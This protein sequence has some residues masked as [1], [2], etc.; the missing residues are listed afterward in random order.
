MATQIQK[1]FIFRLVNISSTTRLMV[2]TSLTETA[3][4]FFIVPQAQVQNRAM[5]LLVAEEEILSKGEWA[6]FHRDQIKSFYWTLCLNQT[7]DTIMF[8]CV[9]GGT[10]SAIRG[11]KHFNELSTFSLRIQT[12]VPMEKATKLLNPKLHRIKQVLGHYQ[13]C[14]IWDLRSMWSSQVFLLKN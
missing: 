9:C 1:H 4:P 14:E 12:H 3:G 13:T 5:S 11:N 2:Q 10:K 7:Q 8:V 6:W